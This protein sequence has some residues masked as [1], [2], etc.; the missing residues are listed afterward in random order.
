MNRKEIR[1]AA[2]RKLDE[3]KI[4][5]THESRLHQAI[6]LKEEAAS[7]I[8]D[9]SNLN[10]EDKCILIRCYHELVLCAKKCDPLKVSHYEAQK[11]GHHKTLSN[12]LPLEDAIQKAMSKKRSY[13]SS[14][15]YQRAPTYAPPMLVKQPRAKL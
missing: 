14:Y 4:F 7:L 8:L 10:D 2:L 6:R 5:E 15:L 1:Q 9:G 13:P 3:S 11:L 12:P